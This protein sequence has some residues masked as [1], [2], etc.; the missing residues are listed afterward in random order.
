MTSLRR[1]PTL[2]GAFPI[3]KQIPSAD[4]SP[5]RSYPR[6]FIRAFEAEN[7]HKTSRSP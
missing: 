6:G 7:A 2:A 5:Q 3:R 1:S 4:V